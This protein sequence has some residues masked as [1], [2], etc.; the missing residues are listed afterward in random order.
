MKFLERGFM[1][2]LFLLAYCPVIVLIGSLFFKQINTVDKVYF[3]STG[4]ASS[5]C[6]LCAYNFGHASMNCI[7][8]QALVSSIYAAYYF[9]FATPAGLATDQVATNGGNCE[10]RLQSQLGGDFE[11]AVQEWLDLLHAQPKLTHFNVVCDSSTTKGNS[12]SFVAAF[13]YET[14]MN[15]VINATVVFR[16]DQVGDTTRLVEID[17]PVS[18]VESLTYKDAIIKWLSDSYTSSFLWGL[19]RSGS[20]AARDAPNVGNHVTSS[21][22]GDSGDGQGN[23]NVGGGGNHDKRNVGGSGDDQVNPKGRGAGNHENPKVGAGG[24]HVHLDVGNHGNP[25]VGD[26]GDGKVTS[27]VAVSDDA[28]INSIVGVSEDAR[29]ESGGGHPTL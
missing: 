13:G 23:P 27:N 26:S 4:V 22:V 21:N 3:T 6:A 11:K 20:L 7:L 19:S 28:R 25:N 16:F 29:A 18:T 24:N 12:G 1:R 8:G 9:V 17:A 5:A 10:I 15:G 14:A 2:F